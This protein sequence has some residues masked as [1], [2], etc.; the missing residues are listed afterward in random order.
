MEKEK[1]R[2]RLKAKEGRMEREERR[3]CIRR[4]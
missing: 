2:E 1:R 3:K 4:L